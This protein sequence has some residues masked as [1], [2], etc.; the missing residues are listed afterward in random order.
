MTAPFLS[1]CNTAVLMWFWFCKDGGGQPLPVFESP[2]GLC[3]SFFIL[4]AS[5][6]DSSLQPTG[7]GDGLGIINTKL[8]VFHMITL[9]LKMKSSCW[10]K[11]L[12]QSSFFPTVQHTCRKDNAKRKKSSKA[13][14]A[15]IRSSRILIRIHKDFA[16]YKLSLS[17]QLQQ[18]QLQT[19]WSQKCNLFFMYSEENTTFSQMRN[20]DDA[21]RCT[22]FKLQSLREQKL[23]GSRQPHQLQQNKR[24]WFWQILSYQI[25]Y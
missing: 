22:S 5:S 14:Q 12:L 7:V 10:I 21:Q 2:T 23:S 1:V 4:E 18:F 3:W 15:S 8:P 17:N 9:N 24:K 6:V 20:I 19:W 16:R 25:H 13:W 11:E